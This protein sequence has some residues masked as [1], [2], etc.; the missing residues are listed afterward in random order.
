[1]NFYPNQLVI[2]INYYIFEPVT[3]S[4][5]FNF[6]HVFEFLTK[7]KSSFCEKKEVFFG[8]FDFCLYICSVV[9]DSAGYK[10]LSKNI[11]KTL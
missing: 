7:G 2:P 5:N 6:Y 10:P 9:I 11:V 4:R 3:I 1:M 8:G